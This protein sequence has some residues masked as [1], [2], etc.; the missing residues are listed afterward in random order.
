[1]IGGMVRNLEAVV[2][3]RVDGVSRSVDVSAVVDTEFTGELTLPMALVIELRLGFEADVEA[4]LAD[5][6]I[7]HA[8]EYAG[9]V[10]WIGI[11]RPVTIVAGEADV[12]LGMLLM[13]GHDLCVEI[14]E[15]GSVRIE[16]HR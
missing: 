5:S 16:G 6:T 11:D 8:E 2:G 3:L 13:N 10:E 9:I 4:A 14:V 15:G 7:V 1:M 12:L